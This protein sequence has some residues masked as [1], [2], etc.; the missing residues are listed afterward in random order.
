[1]YKKNPQLSRK[2]A[3]YADFNSVLLRFLSIL[4]W[5]TRYLA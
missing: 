2:F 1:M 3:K 5:K 4:M